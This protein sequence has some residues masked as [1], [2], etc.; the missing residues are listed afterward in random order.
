MDEETM[1]EQ[2]VP[3]GEEQEATRERFDQEVVRR[4]FEFSGQLVSD[5]PELEVVTVVPSW[6]IPQQDL[7]PAVYVT[8]EGAGMSPHQLML[9]TDRMIR[10]LEF[11]VGKFR[12]FML[13]AG[14]AADKQA[15]ILNERQQAI[16]EKEAQLTELEKKAVERINEETEAKT[17]TP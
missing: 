7:P 5:I 13:A 3:E 11:Q 8:R 15:E 9:V 17:S 12:E 10:A 16:E 6:G 14:D 2:Q 4:I 1:E